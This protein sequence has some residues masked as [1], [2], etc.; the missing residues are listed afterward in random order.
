MRSRLQS[1]K[2]VPLA[3]MVLA[4]LAAISGLLLGGYPLPFVPSFT[5]SQVAV[6]SIGVVG[7]GL[8][9]LLLRHPDT[10]GRI[11][12]AVYAIV[13]IPPL[14]RIGIPGADLLRFV[15]LALVAPVVYGLFRDGSFTKSQAFVAR[16]VFFAVLS[17]VA[18]SLIVNFGDSD[19]PR[20][21]LMASGIVI[22]AIAAP[23]AWGSLWTEAV[24]R[25]VHLVFVMIVI[26]A[27]FTLLSTESMQNERFRGF[28]FSANTVGA[29]LAITAPIAAS[30]SRFPLLYWMS[31][32]AIV[33]ASGSRGGMLALGAGLVYQLWRSRRL[34]IAIAVALVGTVVLSMGV[35][36]IQADQEETLGVNSRE[37]IWEEVAGEVVQR[38]LV[39]HG[40]GSI[41]DFE[42]SENTRRFAGQQPETH[43]SWVDA[44]Y[45][46][47]VVGFALFI[48]VFGLALKHSRLAGS[49]WTATLIAGLVSATFESWMFSLGGGI[50]TIYWMIL[51][52]AIGVHVEAEIRSPQEVEPVS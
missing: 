5:A 47:G 12:P 25:A 32:A 18:T 39:G 44:L 43:S 35:V 41:R 24:A 45:E 33:I 46:Q 1:F 51:G 2:L 22:L 21:V 20:L 17:T 38:P 34:D 48:S 4:G 28:F 49:A 40:F 14:L 3:L 10:I 23:R 37:L 6:A 30:R 16:I 29:L 19:L 26:T 31:A 11:A 13:G 52:A 36:R 50:G 15:P 8:V 7:A 27:P 42:F 9:A